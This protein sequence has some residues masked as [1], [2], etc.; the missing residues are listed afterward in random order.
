MR[1]NL[2]V[3]YK[4]VLRKMALRRTL[5]FCFLLLPVFSCFLLSSCKNSEKK[6]VANQESKRKV[7]EKGT[8]E[9]TE[10]A[11]NRADKEKTDAGEEGDIPHF[12]I[13]EVGVVRTDEKDGASLYQIG[14][15]YLRLKEKGKQFDPL[16]EAL[17]N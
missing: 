3:F 5:L 17:K 12:L 15:N 8:E 1:D 14:T 6:D 7:P 13:K 11:G 16:R 10:V 9:E 2:L 4:T